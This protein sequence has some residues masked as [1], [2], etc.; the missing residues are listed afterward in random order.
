MAR[1][2]AAPRAAPVLGFLY[3]A[4]ALYGRGGRGYFRNTDHGIDMLSAATYEEFIMPI[5]IE[6]NLR[7]GTPMPSGLHYCGR[8]ERL[9]PVI[10]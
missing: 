7:R 10:Q 1:R 8:G 3:P 5:A 4:R 9:F 6:M 2:Q